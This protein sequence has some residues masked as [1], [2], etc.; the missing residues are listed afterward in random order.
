MNI[1][2]A[3]N[4]NNRKLVVSNKIKAFLLVKVQMTYG[5]WQHN[6]NMT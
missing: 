1:W 5:K 3:V 4:M 6:L 2:K